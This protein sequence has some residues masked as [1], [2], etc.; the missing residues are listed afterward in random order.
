[1]LR[2]LITYR[3]AN[4]NNFVKRSIIIEKNE[5]NLVTQMKSMNNNKQF[6]KA[7]QLFD[8]HN[9]NNK[10]TDQMSN[11]VFTQ[12]LKSC[13]GLRDFQRGTKIHDIVSNRLDKDSY[14]LTS[15]IHFYMQCNQVTQAEELFNIVKEKTLPMFG[16]LMKG[17]ITNHQAN[18]VITLFNQ[19]DHPDETIYILVLNACAQLKTNQALIL[20]KQIVN[21]VQDKLQSNSYLSTSLLDALAKCGDMIEAERLFHS[22]VNKISPMHG[23]L[24]KGYIENQMENKVIEHFK[25]IE[26]PSES[27]LTLFFNACAQLKTDE[28]LNLIKKT[29]KTISKSF[30]LNSRLLTSLLDA[31]VKCG[32]L[33]YA[34]NL[35]DQLPQKTLSMYKVMINGYLK[36]NNSFKILNLFSEMKLKHIEIDHIIWTSIIKALA[37]IG[38]LEL[39]KSI[40]EQI[41]ESCL[42]DNQIHNALIHMWGKSGCVD[43]AEKVFKKI[44]QPNTIGYAA[45][46]NAY[47]LNGQGLKAI[48]LYEKVPGE[49]INEATYIC[50]LNACSHAG[51]VDKALLIFNKIEMKTER[52]YTVMIDCLSRSFFFI[53]AQQLINEYESSH[54]PSAPMYLALLSAA[55]NEKNHHLSQEIYNRMKTHFSQLSDSITSAA[56]L[57]S[58]VYGSIG[59]ME[60]VSEIRTKLHRSGAKKKI[61]LSWTVINGQVYEFRAHDQSHPQSKEIYDEIEKI[62]NELVQ[63]GHQYD[64][65][66]ITR[67]INQDETV[68]SVLC[69]HSER[70]AIAWNFVAK[71]NTSRIQLGKNLRICGDC[72][73]AIKLIA[74]IRQCEIVVR[75]ANRIHHFF[76]NGQCSCNNFF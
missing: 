57:L 3:L 34:Q 25:H 48:E 35:F 74:N 45:M 56:I 43:R 17:Y 65:S 50:I 38:D 63:H 44:S 32:D 11:L 24:M 39:S 41:P 54:L 64:S 53:E 46:I 21:I 66:W 29:S 4:I 60:K 58:N 12:V 22:L 61:G 42:I 73:S 8:E 75:D 13:T 20:T 19:I 67:P 36:E 30:S 68:S 52:I 9:N 51:L 2:R 69:G 14:L 28:A 10:N 49:F 15:L 76:K 55:R 5:R 7:L 70:L 71:P 31:L 72:H 27:V 18:K 16:A 62:S 33:N 1:M 40:V 47:G 59:D 6:K 23:A 26:K 37:Y